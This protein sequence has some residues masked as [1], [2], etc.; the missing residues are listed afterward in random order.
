VTG[1]DWNMDTNPETARL[2]RQ[3]LDR[4]RP[5]ATAPGRPRK[6]PGLHD[7]TRT[8]AGRRVF[9]YCC[10]T[11]ERLAQVQIVRPMIGMC[12]RGRRSSGSAT[13]ASASSPA[14]SSSARA[15]RLSMS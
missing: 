1:Y 15:V 9:T 6:D 13:R 10:F 11:A 12:C 14:M 2:R 8:E 3:L 7:F 5:L 4:L